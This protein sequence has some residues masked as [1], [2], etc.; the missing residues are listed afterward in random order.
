MST[1]LHLSAQEIRCATVEFF[2]RRKLIRLNGRELITAR[3]NG[4]TKIEKL[5]FHGASE[6]RVIFLL[7]AGN[8]I[9]RVGVSR[10]GCACVWVGEGAWST[11]KTT[12]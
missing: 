9:L 10:R 6:I 11:T 12:T 1:H 3:E 5:I 7:A 4:E 2:V 8:W